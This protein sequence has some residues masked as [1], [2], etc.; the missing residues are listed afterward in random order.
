MSQSHY[1]E[2]FSSLTEGHLYQFGTH[3]MSMSR[4]M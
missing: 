1:S 4:H 3:V 2:F